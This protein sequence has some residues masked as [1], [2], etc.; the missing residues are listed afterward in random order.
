ML[1]ENWFQDNSLKFN[2]NKTEIH[3][4]QDRD[5]TPTRP[6]FNTHKTEI[7]HP[8]DRDLTPTRPR[9][10]THE[11]EIQ[12]PQDRDS[13]PTRPRFNTHKTEIH[14]PQDR[15]PQ[16]RDSSPTRP[17]FNTHKTEIQH[18][19]VRFNAHKTERDSTLEA[20]SEFQHQQVWFN[21]HNFYHKWDSISRSE[22]RSHHHFTQFQI[23]SKSNKQT[24]TINGILIT[25]AW[26]TWTIN[27]FIDF[28]ST[29][30]QKGRVPT[31]SRVTHWN[32]QCI[33]CHSVLWTSNKRWV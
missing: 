12:H 32:K 15:D 8:Q 16:D 24:C 28:F 3:H 22:I 31:W 17:R 2:T 26:M 23:N 6:R 27:Y 33:H 5:S 1:L 25:Y 9:F 14:H 29:S 30:E 4:P 13:S 20:K 7:H 11:T 21:V 19:K 18:P 10:N